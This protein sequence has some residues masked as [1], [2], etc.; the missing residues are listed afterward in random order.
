MSPQPDLAVQR[1]NALLSF[2]QSLPAG[3]TTPLNLSDADQCKHAEVML[4]AAGRFSDAYPHLYKALYGGSNHSPEGMDTVHLVD[5]GKTAAGKATASVM[6]CSGG[7]N[8]ISGG[9]LVIFDADSGEL[10]AQG[11][12]TSV[13]SGVVVCSTRAASALPAGKKL[14]VLYLGHT[15]GDDGATRFFSYANTVSVGNGITVKVTDPVIKNSTDGLIHLGVG[16]TGGYPTS[17]Y[18][19][20]EPQNLNNPWV[21]SPFTGTVP[22]SGVI[23]IQHLTVA[24]LTTNIVIQ[25]TGGTNITLNRSTQFTPDSRFVAAF[26]VG[27]SPNILQFNFPYDGLSHSNTRSI[28]YDSTSFGSEVVSYFYF[29]F[30]GIP[31]QGGAVAPPFYV[32]SINFPDE[33]SLNC[34]KIPNLYY[35]WHC[36]AKGTLVTLED[37]S[38]KPIEEITQDYRVKTADGK[39]LGVYATVKGTHTSN[40]TPGEDGIYKV[41]TANGK[42]FVATGDH[43]VFTAAN[44]CSSVHDLAAGDGILTEE[45][46]STVKS[47]DAI[48]YDD[49]F[50]ALALGHPDEQA[51]P[52]FPKNMAGY[53][54]AGVLHA[55]QNAMRIQTAARYK[56]PDYMLPRMKQELH[57]DYTSALNDMRS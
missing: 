23:D 9:H 41:T 13:R 20:T 16:R 18:I 25:K 15:T 56:D 53:Y 4:Q 43:M 36:L 5:S 2:H 32:C 39:S 35:W 8:M 37:G 29:A 42:S 50:Y 45:G 10:L 49:T 48:S 54:A 44:K 30:N 34:T 21:I 26:F 1:A 33:P 55:D 47:K 11:E 31:L 19:Y 40:G 14:S 12:N 51:A 7:N 52:G 3:K 28:V 17:D 46:V 22:L 24:D 6:A 57:Q 27:I 38:Q